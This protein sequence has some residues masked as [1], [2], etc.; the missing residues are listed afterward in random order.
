MIADERPPNIRTNPV[1]E[2]AALG[3]WHHWPDPDVSHDERTNRERWRSYMLPTLQA[4]TEAEKEAEGGEGGGG[5]GAA[6][7]GMVYLED[8]LI[9]FEGQMEEVEVWKVPRVGVD[10]SGHIVRS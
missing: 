6:G 10:K 8:V 9:R 7:G 1:S 3:T 5:G 2:C 4:K